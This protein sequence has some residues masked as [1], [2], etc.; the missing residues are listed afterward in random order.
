MALSEGYGDDLSAEQMIEDVEPLIGWLAAKYVPRDHEVYRDLVQE[1][2][3]KYWAVL[4]SH[5][6]QQKSYYVKSAQQ[7]M[8]DVFTRRAP[9]LGSADGINR[10]RPKTTAVDF[11]EHP[12]LIDQVQIA[13][14]PLDLIVASYHEGEVRQALDLLCEEDRVYVIERFWKGTKGIDID[15]MLGLSYGRG[16]QRWTR[17][18]KPRLV[19]A[20]AQIDREVA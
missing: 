18:I 16:A 13:P 3:M 9:M 10:Y 15:A 1:G 11:A 19:E 17:R 7:R 14:D 4:R 12:Y 20:L 5:P 6:D 2:L 8:L